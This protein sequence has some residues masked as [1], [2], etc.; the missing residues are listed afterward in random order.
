MHEEELEEK[1]KV[2]R[3]KRMIKGEWRKEKNMC[4]KGN[5]TKKNMK[6]EQRKKPMKVDQI[7][8]KNERNW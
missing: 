1:G 7:K 3:K 5:F 6:W 8:L 4:L 2:W